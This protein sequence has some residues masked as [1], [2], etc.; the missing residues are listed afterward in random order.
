MRYARG[1]ERPKLDDDE[2]YVSDHSNVYSESR[3]SIVVDEATVV[4]SNE[5]VLNIAQNE[6]RAVFL[7]RLV[8]FGAL[9][10]AA[11]SVSVVVYLITSNGEHNSFVGQFHG[12]A[13]KVA[14]SFNQIVGQKMA[15]IGSVSIAYTSFARSHD[16]V[17]F[18][19]VTMP[20]FPQLTAQARHLSN[21]LTIQFIPIVTDSKRVEWEAYTANNSW[22]LTEGSNYQESLGL[23]YDQREIEFVPPVILALKSGSAA[24][25]PGPG[26]Y[27]PTWQISPVTEYSYSNIN[28]IANGSYYARTIATSIETGKILISNLEVAG[29]GSFENA[30]AHY[31]TR[32]YSYLLSFAGGVPTRY[33]GD[34]ISFIFYPVFDSFNSSD[35]DVVGVVSAA[36]NWA[37][38]FK[39]ILPPNTPGVY[40]VLENPCQR[41]ITRNIT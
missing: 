39:D 15:A 33:E 16:T 5:D 2:S 18:P 8:V 34:P 3:H 40:I 26:P 21:A 14:A 22:W 30:T 38:Y 7:Q 25:E 36:I 17:E 19:F 4:D 9:L 31:Y 11:I 13:A 37:L 24:P 12:T 35:R 28:L 10:V 29:A 27:M 1:G 23:G 41:Y 20:D 6:T 32:Y